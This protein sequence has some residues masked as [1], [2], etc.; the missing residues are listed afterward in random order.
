ME[1]KGT[2]ELATRGAII[3]PASTHR[4]PRHHR[5]CA[6]ALCVALALRVLPAAAGDLLSTSPPTQAVPESLWGSIVVFDPSI[7]GDACYMPGLLGLFCFR[8]DTFT[9][10]GEYVYELWERFPT[11]W[12]VT[13]VVV[14]TPPDPLCQFGG[15]WLPMAWSFQTPPH[16]PRIYQVRFQAEVDCCTA[17]YCVEAVAGIGTLDA[18]V[19]WYWDGFGSF[20][21][22]HHPCSNDGYTPAGQDACDQATQ[23]LSS[24]PPCVLPPVLLT[25]DV[26]EI[27]G[28][29]VS[30]QVHAITAWN[31]AGSG[32]NMAMSYSILDGTGSCS[33]PATVAV[34]TGGSTPFN[35]EITAAGEL[36]DT[37]VC[38]I[39]AVDPSDPG[40]HDESLLV[41]HVVP[42]VWDPVG[43]QNQT[44]TGA[45]PAQ[46][47]SCAAGWHP[48]AP[49]EVGYQVGGLDSS[50]SA[51]ALLQMYNPAGGAWAQ[52]APAPQALFGHV[53]SFIGNKLYVSGGFDSG[54][55]GSPNLQV[56]DPASNT[57][58]DTGYPDIPATGGRGGGAGGAGTC[59]TGSGLCH[60]NVGGSPNAGYPD[61]TL[62]TWEFNPATNAWTQLDSKPPGASPDG[63]VL[64]AGV[65]CMGRIFVGG[66]FR[67]FHDF[68]GLDATAPSGSQWVQLAPIPD[69]GGAAEPAM[70]CSDPEGA[71]YLIGGD[72]NGAWRTHNTTVYRYDMFADVWSGP[73]PFQLNVAVIG[74]CGLAMADGLRTFGGS[75]DGYPIEPPP[76]EL[77]QAIACPGFLPFAD[78]FETGD[79][80]A[81]SLT[82]P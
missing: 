75:I 14:G 4:S 5:S 69:P 1:C 39:A 41:E 29:P 56:F 49:V 32:M 66:D 27:E 6:T 18:P 82:V 74:S 51:Q 10:D 44:V 55:V 53:A 31:N 64:G 26:I 70:V 43:W 63:F 38:E 58:D 62:E 2:A 33:G 36:G 40:N 3:T 52:L 11:D 72:P 78:G 45:F 22:P 81:W 13:D 20:Y 34:A 71:V 47:A 65:G 50:N 68:F 23:P 30:P 42:F 67:G 60:F 7:G 19:S 35:V 24:I 46:S 80:S 61:T 12:A 15:S 59:H 37:T 48:W 76:H 57:W 17:Y 77:L 73:L 54:W 16:E 9:T 8:T 21:P 28:C 79:T 25:P